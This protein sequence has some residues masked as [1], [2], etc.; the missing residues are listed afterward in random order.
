MTTTYLDPVKLG[1]FALLSG[2]F[3]VTDP[4]YSPDTWCAGSI[5]ARN[6][7]W[8]AQLVRSNEKEWGERVAE[9]VIQHIDA[10]LVLPE[11]D[12]EITVGVDSGQAGF[13]CADT[14]AAVHK[15]EYGEPGFY[16]TVCTLTSGGGGLVG[17]GVASSSGF[18][19]GSYQCLVR[20]NARDEIETA[21]IIFIG[22][23]PDEDE[24]GED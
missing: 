13:F 24:E 11:V 15:S 1:K 16:G 3:Q 10:N 14:Y 9:L 21:R 6:G 23:E 7:V 4:C 17:F 12:S 2:K 19:D 8:D 22:D 20:K 18:G 5:A